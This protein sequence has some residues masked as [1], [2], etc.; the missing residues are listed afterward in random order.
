ML[1][2]GDIITAEFDTQFCGIITRDIEITDI[3][4]ESTTHE[5]IIRGKVTDSDA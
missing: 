2:K 1:K 3:F 4:Q 5:I